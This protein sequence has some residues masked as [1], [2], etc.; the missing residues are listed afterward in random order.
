MSDKTAEIELLLPFYVNGTLSAAENLQVE[1]ALAA[2]P[3]LADE[4]LFLQ[5]LQQNIKEQPQKEN[6]PGEMGLQ[7]LQHHL[8]HHKTVKTNVNT[9]RYAAIAAS[10]LLL[11]QTTVTLI[12][13][14]PDIFIPAGDGL[15]GADKAELIINV[16]FSPTATE[17]EIRALLIRLDATIIDGPSALGLYRIAPGMAASKALEALKS[18]PIIESAHIVK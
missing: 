15:S 4:V 6:S 1:Q 10:L 3:E 17:A 7:R 9:W 13:P 2:K 12:S 5:Q 18:E 16:T 14:T 11:V 8:K